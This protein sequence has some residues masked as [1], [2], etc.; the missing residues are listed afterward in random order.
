M[1]SPRT[2]LD[3]NFDC[4]TSS[5]AILRQPC[6]LRH[7]YPFVKCFHKLSST[8]PAAINSSKFLLCV[9]RRDLIL[10]FPG[11]DFNPLNHPIFHQGNS[12]NRPSPTSRNPCIHRHPRQVPISAHPAPLD[13]C[14]FGRNKPR[15]KTDWA[16]LTDRADQAG[17]LPNR[18]SRRGRH[19]T[20][21][22]ILSC[23]G[24]N[25]FKPQQHRDTEPA[26]SR[27]NPDAPQPSRGLSAKS[28]KS[29]QSAPPWVSRP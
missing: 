3:L 9:S 18:I 21:C 1:T 27:A 19:Q 5:H 22:R 11:P 28:V 8:N 29:A 23:F 15:K 13:R 6:I 10:P 24:S 14:G 2:S 26:G 12:F 25:Q 4:Q 7:Y 17:R 20:Q 16:D